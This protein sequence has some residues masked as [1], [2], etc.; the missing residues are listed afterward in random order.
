MEPYFARCIEQVV[1]PRCAEVAGEQ[2]EG[3]DRAS[4]QVSGHFAANVLDGP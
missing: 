2:F 3:V 1:Y 4:E